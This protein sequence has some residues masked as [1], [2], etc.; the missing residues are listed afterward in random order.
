MLCCILNYADPA[1]E[2]VCTIC[3]LEPLIGTDELLI[4]AGGTLLGTANPM[5]NITTPINKIIRNIIMPQKR[6]G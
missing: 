1:L 5:I 3:P 2:E 4:G 6:N